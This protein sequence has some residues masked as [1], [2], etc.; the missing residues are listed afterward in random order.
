MTQGSSLPPLRKNDGKY[1]LIALLLLVAAGG[2]WFFLK[3]DDS[4]SHSEVVEP[5]PEPTEAKLVARLIARPEAP[6]PTEKQLAEIVADRLD[7]LRGRI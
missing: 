5:A 2:L 6:A 3:S 4:E 7:L 1:G